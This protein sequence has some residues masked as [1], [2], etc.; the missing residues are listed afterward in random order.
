MSEE[1]SFHVVEL[2]GLVSTQARKPDSNGD[3]LVSVDEEARQG[4]P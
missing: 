2:T 1:V 3:R 4:C